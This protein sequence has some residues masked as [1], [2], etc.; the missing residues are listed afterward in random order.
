[1]ILHYVTIGCGYFVACL[2]VCRLTLFLFDWMWEPPQDDG[3]E[4]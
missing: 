4:P 2:L 1:M 3:S